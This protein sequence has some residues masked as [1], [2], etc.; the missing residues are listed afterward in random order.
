MLSWALL[1][2]V[3]AGF[4]NPLLRCEWCDEFTLYR[5]VVVPTLLALFL[6]R[7]VSPIAWR[8]V[9]MGWLGLFVVVVWPRCILRQCGCPGWFVGPCLLPLTVSTSS[10]VVTN[11]DLVAVLLTDVERRRCKSGVWESR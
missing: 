3:A 5:V 9:E 2:V 6:S 1:T 10:S 11:Y 7:R 8:L 4:L